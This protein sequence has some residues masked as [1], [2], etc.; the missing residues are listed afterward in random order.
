M[1]KSQMKLYTALGLLEGCL[2]IKEMEEFDKDGLIRN[3]KEIKLILTKYL[4]NDK[5]LQKERN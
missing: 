2:Y 1:S 3:L 5:I 4:D